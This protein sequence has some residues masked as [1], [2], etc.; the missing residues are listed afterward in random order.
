MPLLFILCLLAQQPASSPLQMKVGDAEL[1]IGGFLDATVVNRSTAT[2]NGL[3]T[4]FGTIPFDNTPQGNLAETK[5]TAQNSRL[6]MQVTS[7]LGAM[8]V[9]GYVEVDFGGNAPNAL[10]VT[11]NGNTLRMRL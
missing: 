10:N 8:N 2:G 1:R 5:L 4:A 7:P 3:P 9:K 11:S 6:S